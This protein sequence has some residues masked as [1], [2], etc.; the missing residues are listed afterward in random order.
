VRTL[1][2]SIATFAQAC[3]PAVPIALRSSRRLMP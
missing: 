2:P 3:R 1:P